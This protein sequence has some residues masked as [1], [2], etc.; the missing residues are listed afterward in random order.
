MDK[1]QKFMEGDESSNQINIG[2]G[3]LKVL[4]HQ[5][6]NSRPVHLIGEEKPLHL[7]I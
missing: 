2:Q 1:K 6:M 5:G 7:G 4:N 3:T